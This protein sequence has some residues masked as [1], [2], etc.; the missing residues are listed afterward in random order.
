M[1]KQEHEP[2]ALEI[3]LERAY[4]L[5]DIPRFV[6]LVSKKMGLSR[7]KGSG[8]GAYLFQ[9][10]LKQIE[11]AKKDHHDLIMNAAKGDV[12]ND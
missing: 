10:V 1:K 3:A 12:G 6:K 8:D 11:Q 2:T 7:N 4:R 9:Y 5:R